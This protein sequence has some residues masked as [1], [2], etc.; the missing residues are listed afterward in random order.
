MSMMDLSVVIPIF[1]EAENIRGLYKGIL[2]AL[3]PTS[4]QFEVLF[5]DDGSTDQTLTVLRRL[6]ADDPRVTAIRLRRNFGQ[7][8]AMRAG[9]DH[10]RGEIVVTM[11]GDL[12]N[13]PLD[14]PILVDKIREGFDLVTGW[15]QNRK[16][17]WVSRK[18][19]SKIAN[20]LI[21]AVTDVP[22]HDTGC[23]LKAYRGGLIRQ[24][25]LYS[26]MHRFVPAISTMAT[27]RFAEVK[28]RH[29]PR[30]H[31][32]S[33]YGLSRVWRVLLDVLTVKM[34]VSSSRRP[35]HWF[36]LGAV[37][38]AVLAIG[39]AAV[40]GQVLWGPDRPATI[41]PP[42]VSLLMAYLAVHM[43]LVGLFG[44]LVVHTEPARRVEP[45][46][47]CSSINSADALLDGRE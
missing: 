16:D 37:L 35:L 9:I 38:P 45:L 34:L 20:W 15:R 14:I 1:N 33:K 31:G 11:D 23:S 22:I 44:E 25:P 18:L 42:V 32:E 4:E 36:G 13:D 7:T 24:L 28:V 46:A 40:W 30:R 19:P 6:V 26:D 21:A 43:L 5:V 29:H 12:Q 17:V 8:P 41:V 10:C 47:A 39:A 3:E 2:D 27:V